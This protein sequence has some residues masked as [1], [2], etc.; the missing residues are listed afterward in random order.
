MVQ[1]LIV[2]VDGSDAAWK[3]VDTALSLARKTDSS[4]HIVEVVFA[5]ADTANAQIRLEEG[6]SAIDAS[7]L[8]VDVEVLLSDETVASAIDAAVIARPGSTVVMSSHGRGRSAALVGSIAEDVLQRT[9]GPIILVGPHVVVDDFSGPIIVTVD[10]S[11]ESEAALPLAA[12]WGIEL[13]VSPWVVNVIPPTVNTDSR[14]DIIDTMY[15]ARLAHELSAQSGHRVEFEELHDGH[16]AVSVPEF[17]E[18][19]D[20]SL[21]VASSHGRSG[22]SRLTIGSVTSGFVR[23][24][25]CPVMIVRLPH[26]THRW[27]EA[28]ARFWAM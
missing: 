11:D 25:T 8:E 2:P 16:P 19:M 12:A 24:A 15:T 5:R 21:I 9:F 4:V 20:A 23:H 26:P 18:R 14:S 7:D 3:A 27:D 13:G 10:G 28:D 1:R 22:L 6:I 17:A